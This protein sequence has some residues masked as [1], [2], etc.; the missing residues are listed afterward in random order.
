MLGGKKA[1][2]P[3]PDRIYVGLRGISR[4]AAIENRF[5]LTRL[6]INDFTVH[7]RNGSRLEEK[8]LFSYI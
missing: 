1:L 4:I 7:A 3:K 8:R 2:R 5:R 6:S